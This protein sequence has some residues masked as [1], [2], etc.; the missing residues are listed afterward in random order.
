MA[1]S[2]RRRL[3]I[4]LVAAVALG[5]ALDQALLHT[6]LADD[7]FRGHFVA[8]FD[9]PLFIAPQFQHLEDTRR[10]LAGDEALAQ[11]SLFDP[12]LGWCPRPDSEAFGAR[13]DGLGARVGA[14]AH[15]P[16]PTPGLRR[17]VTLGGSFTMG[18]EVGEP[19]AWP[20]QVEAARGDL[21]VINLGVA[22]F[23][24]DQAYLR[25]RRDGVRLGP[26]EVWFGLMPQATLRVA[27]HYAPT[28]YRWSTIAAF[29]PRFLP[30]EGD[31]LRHVPNPVQKHADYVR[32]LTDQS[33]FC[34]AMET[35]LW[36]ARTPAAFAPRG[37]SPWHWSAVGRL[38]LTL[39]ESRGRDRALWLEDPRSEVY[40]LMRNL[41]L[42][43][44]RDARG[45]G[46]VLRVVVLPSRADL[47]LR[48]AAGAGFW[49]G[50]LEE[51]AGRG[52]EAFDASEA[53]MVAGALGDPS[54]WM[55]GSHYSAA[56]NRVVAEALLE[57]WFPGGD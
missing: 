21:E 43:F 18:M 14:Q 27:T 51:L 8:P 50:L 13:F 47:E 55:P 6:A 46:A 48:D 19:E 29:K 22:G 9:P 25:F 44:D 57:A 11:R 56:G 30:A 52:I 42:A 2:T 16:Q 17:V 37:S 38:G 12:E 24:L 31:G 7:R 53:L 15:G 20:A 28:Y 41:L 34:A 4:G 40:R 54:L 49:E 36:V 1:R 45:A 32:L 33:A 35:D 10:I 5:L 26:D 39:L 3:G 23:G